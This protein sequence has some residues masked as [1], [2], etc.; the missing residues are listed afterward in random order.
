MA[1][2]V[3]ETVEGYET[4]SENL[5]AVSLESDLVFADGHSLQLAKVTGSVEEGYTASLTVPV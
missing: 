2:S 3:Y 5:A 1:S 4:S